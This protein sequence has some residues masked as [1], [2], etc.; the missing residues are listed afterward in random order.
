MKKNQIIALGAFTVLALLILAFVPPPHVRVADPAEQ[1]VLLGTFAGVTPCADCPGIETRVTL[2][3]YTPYSAEGTY[4]LSLTYL[5]SDGATYTETGVWTT[6]RG[7]STNPDAEVYALY[8]EGNE[9]PA[10]YV[11]LTENAI[12]QLDGDGN[13]IDPNLPFTLL[14]VPAAE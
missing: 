9:T 11:R 4:E 13:E 5:E 2:M 10:R 14:R 1:P 3:Q 8:A 12:R 7:T 6:E